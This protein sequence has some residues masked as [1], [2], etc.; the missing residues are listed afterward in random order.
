ML[1][2]HQDRGEVIGPHHVGDADAHFTPLQP[3]EL[4]HLRLG[5][6]HLQQQALGMAAE[7]LP[8]RGEP[9]AAILPIE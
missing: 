4:G 8:L 9:H 7:H 5:L 3:L 2:R 1:E 6:M